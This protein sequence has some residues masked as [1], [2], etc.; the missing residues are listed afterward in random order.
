M[1][2][3]IK[4][5][6]APSLPQMQVNCDRGL[7]AKLDKYDVT[8]FLNCH[9]CNLVVGRPGSGKS[10]F[11]YAL[12]KSPKL[13]RKVYHS[14][15]LI[16]PARSGASVKDDIFDRLPKDQKYEELNRE[17]MSDLAD[18][19]SSAPAEENN[20]VIMDDVAAYLKSPEIQRLFRELV[21]NRRHMHTSIFLLTQTYYSVPKEI[22]RLFSNL[23]VFKCPK[24]EMKNIFDELFEAQKSQYEGVMAAAFDTKYN[25]LFLNVDSG[26]MFRMF[27]EILIGGLEPP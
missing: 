20:C 4:H 26:R 7:H 6:D 21:M 9:S 23:V 27:D 11:I 19:L 24:A 22:R 2:I 1:P 16:R 25:W 8:K 17:T 13:L 3:H 14:I 15:Y 5:N 18:R 12:F 10:S